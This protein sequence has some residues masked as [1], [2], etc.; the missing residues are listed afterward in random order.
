MLLFTSKGVAEWKRLH[1]FS[2]L[3]Q[4]PSLVSYFYFILASDEAQF[5]C[6]I[7]VLG[8]EFYLLFFADPSLSSILYFI[9]ASGDA[10]LSCFTF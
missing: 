4:Y 10:Q 6:S 9:L 3:L 8:R 1:S 7:F 5:S 2:L